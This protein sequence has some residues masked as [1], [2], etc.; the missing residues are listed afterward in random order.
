MSLEEKILVDFKAALKAKDQLKVSVLS[1]LRSQLSYLALEKK[2]KPLGDQ[3]CIGAIKKLIKQH[4]DSIEQFTAGKRQDLA[5]KEVKE[6]EILK[7]YL[8]QEMSESALSG[9]VAEVIASTGA[10]GIKDMG[11]VMKE[12]LAKTAGAA[13][14]KMVSEIVKARL[15]RPAS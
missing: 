10:A 11:K 13:D 9:V 5:D 14:G 7:A 15:T 1:F 8:P 3:D 12:V 2:D 4:Q 6:L